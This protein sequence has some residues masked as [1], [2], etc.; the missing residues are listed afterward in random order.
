LRWR[1]SLN[2]QSAG[3]GAGK[4]TNRPMDLEQNE[5]G[6]DLVLMTAAAFLVELIEHFLRI[7]VA[8]GEGRSG[9]AGN[10]RQGD[11]RRQNGL[12]GD[13]LSNAIWGLSP[14]GSFNT[15]KYDP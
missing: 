5:N 4:R 1:S 11:K 6:Q 9:N 10:E 2:E 13:F 7:D 14:C 8:G 12:H 15:G 3:S